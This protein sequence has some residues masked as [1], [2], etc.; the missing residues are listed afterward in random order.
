[1]TQS[2]NPH[3][4]D[5][6]PELAVV[7]LL[8]VAAL[9]TRFALL[10][11]HPA[12]RDPDAAPREN[13]AAAAVALALIALADAVEDEVDAYLLAVKRE[14]LAELRASQQRDF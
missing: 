6:N 1:M 7:T 14:R 5:R 13:D 9:N 3:A 4:L 2:P 12:L 10:S 8:A 11:A